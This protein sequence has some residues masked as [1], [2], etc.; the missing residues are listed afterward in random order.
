MERP[1]KFL[2]LILVTAVAKHRLFY[3]QQKLALFSV[4]RIM[5]IDAADPI[6]Q[7]N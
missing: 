7:V 1:R 4:V 5:A 6:R 3:F 2:L